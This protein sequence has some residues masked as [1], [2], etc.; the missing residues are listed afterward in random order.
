MVGYLFSG[1]RGESG[2]FLGASSEHY[3]GAEGYPHFGRGVGDDAID[4]GTHENHSHIH[5][6]VMLTDLRWRAWSIKKRV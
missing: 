2:H 5:F 1:R 3:V 6:F 4:T